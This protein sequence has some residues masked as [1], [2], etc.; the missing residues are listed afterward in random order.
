MQAFTIEQA[1]MS[2]AIE[3]VR[4]HFNCDPASLERGK[5]IPKMQA[6]MTVAQIEKLDATLKLLPQARKR[7][8]V[9]DAT[10]EAAEL[11]GAEGIWTYE[12][13]NGPA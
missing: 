11:R 12:Q 6:L 2:C 3:R 10:I 5:L 1:A 4:G 7:E 9:V 8:A 13:L